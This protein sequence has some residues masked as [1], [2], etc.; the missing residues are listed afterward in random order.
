MATITNPEHIGTCSCGEKPHAHSVRDWHTADHYLRHGKS[1]HERPLANNTRVLRLWDGDI[2]V[3][4]YST[5][6]VVY[7]RPVYPSPGGYDL[8][9]ENK[10]GE[11]HTHEVVA[12]FTLGG[13]N[14]PTT[15][16]RIMG[17]TPARVGSRK[18]QPIL[19]HE[20]D[21]LSPSRVRKC[22]Q[23]KGEGVL[24]RTCFGA[25][26][27]RPWPCNPPHWRYYNIGPGAM[28]AEPGK[29]CKHGEIDRHQ[30]CKHGHRHEHVIPCQ[31]DRYDYHPLD[32]VTCFRCDGEGR[33]EYGCKPQPT[34]LEIDD[35][36][37]VDATGKL[38][39]L[40]SDYPMDTHP[41]ELAHHSYPKP[42]PDWLY[43]DHY[44]PHTKAPA[45]EPPQPKS[46]PPQVSGDK[47]IAAMGSVVPDIGKLVTCPSKAVDSKFPNMGTDCGVSK[48]LSE[49][50]I[51]LNDTHRWT[52]EAI[53]DWLESTDLDLEF[54][55]R[56]VT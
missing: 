21:P 3:R 54:R 28:D 49:L 20:T 24:P 40:A 5:M 37:A 51:H 48:S 7:P 52:R 8:V 9:H 43:K 16:S 27:C 45:P 39:A 19:R 10:G 30:V 33:A 29:H 32:P 46:Q 35:V 36:V 26:K 12:W 25:H 17:Y 31:H 15:R 6:V 38:V 53:A 2:G 42:K 22:G 1:P 13:W 11:L 14:T 18:N 50:I 23:C 56:E 34:E 41:H 44:G 47:V 4:L 55:R